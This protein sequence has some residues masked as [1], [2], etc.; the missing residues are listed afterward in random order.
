MNQRRMWTAVGLVATAIG[1]TACTGLT[2]SPPGPAA[3][4][5]AGGESIATVK[6]SHIGSTNPGFSQGDCPSDGWGWHFVLPGNSTDFVQLTA[7]FTGDR[8]TVTLVAE[9]YEPTEKHAYVYT[10]GPGWELAASEA[11]VTGSGRTYNLSHVCTGSDEEATTTIP[12]VTTTTLDGSTTTT[13]GDTT[14]L[15]LGGVTTTEPDNTTTSEA[16]DTTT[17]GAAGTTTEAPSTTVPETTSTSGGESTS[18]T[19]S[20]GSTTTTPGGGAGSQVGGEGGETSSTVAVEGGSTTT[21]GGETGSDTLPRTGTNHVPIA[22]LAGL[23]LA[24][25]ATLLLA[26]RKWTHSE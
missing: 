2:V 18:S 14:S 11:L 10:D 8:E 4:T 6:E 22:G 17:T 13:P 9:E 12:I 19:A 1:L 24:A 3:L 20:I 7:T 21:P 15:T 5:P 23:L 26:V 25:G 16:G